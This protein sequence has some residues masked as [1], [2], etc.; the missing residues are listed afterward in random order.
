MIKCDSLSLVQQHIYCPKHSGTW[1]KYWQE[2]LYGNG[3]YDDNSRLP[4]VF[5]EELRPL[6]DRLSNPELLG[7]CYKGLTQNQ[8]ESINS[9][10]WSLCNKRTFCS[11]NTLSLCVTESILKFNYGA[12]TRISLLKEMGCGIGLNV[13]SAIEREDKLRIS[14]A[15]QKISIERRSR[16]QSQRLSRKLKK[17][18]ETDYI[19]GGFEVTTNRTEKINADIVVKFI[20][21][22]TAKS[23]TNVF[24]CILTPRLPYFSLFCKYLVFYQ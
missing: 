22:G 17:T 14:H 13:T 20:D 16:R 23:G 4:S 21:E 11:F 8:N 6:F 19:S 3:S 18:V 2:K 5:R 7:H 10:L 15:Q 24:F 12:S 1:C 9:V